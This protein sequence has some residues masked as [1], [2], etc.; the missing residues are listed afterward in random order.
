M[1]AVLPRSFFDRRAEEVAPGL[2]GCVLTRTT[3]EGAVS[4]RLTEVEAYAGPRD[5]ASHAYRGPTKRNAVMFG[6]PG[7]AYV[8]FTYGMHFCVNLVCLGE[9]T[10]AAVLLRAGEVV[11]GRELAV[12]RRPRSSPRDLARGPARLCE[13]L[14]I[15]REL[16]GTDVCDP[17][18]PL[19]VSAGGPASSF[20]TGPRTGVSSAKD[21]PWRFW[22][23]GDP[24][25]SAYRLHTPRRRTVIDQG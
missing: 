14:A 25:V 22:I 7:H 6:P 15:D 19:R 20:R 1:A 13:A 23:D 10:A 11:E 2:L 5:P 9:G 4:A 21:V 3:A 8:Y 24:S 16:S 12:A 18:S 17:A